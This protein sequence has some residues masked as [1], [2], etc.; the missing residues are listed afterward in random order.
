MKIRWLFQAIRDI[1]NVEK[2]IKRNNITAATR[3]ARL[4]F[5]LVEKQLPVAPQSGRTGRVA[6]T[7]ELVVNRT[8]FIVVYQIVETEIHILSVRHS[9]QLWPDQF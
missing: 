7:R 3:T 4:I 9:S 5:T 2:Y 6:G 1:E 8:P